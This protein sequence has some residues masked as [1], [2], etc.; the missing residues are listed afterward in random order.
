MSKRAQR[1]KENAMIT[2]LRESAP[3]RRSE[4]KYVLE[5][6]TCVQFMIENGGLNL[7]IYRNWLA[8]GE[9]WLFS[10]FF[11]SNNPLVVKLI[12]EFDRSDINTKLYRD[13]RNLLHF[14]TNSHIRTGTLNSFMHEQSKIIQL[15]SVLPFHH[16]LLEKDLN[17]DLPVHVATKNSKTELADFYESETIR[18]KKEINSCLWLS[19]PVSAVHLF[20]MNYLFIKSY[21]K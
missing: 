5:S 2:K 16:L 4:I 19:I 7:Y 14:I 15:L 10:I 17:G 18:Y 20:V 3:L 1:R 13:R 11:L 8:I 6:E 21:C 9:P 12:F